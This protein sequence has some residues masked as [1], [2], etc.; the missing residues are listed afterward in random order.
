MLWVVQN[1]L[2][3]E[4]GYQAFM[5][6]LDRMQSDYIIVKPVPFSDILLPADFDSF[7]SRSK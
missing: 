2:Y 7:T 5:A 6:A 4:H 1:N 3:N